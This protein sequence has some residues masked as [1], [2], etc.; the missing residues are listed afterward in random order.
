MKI[1]MVSLFHR[2]TINNNSNNNNPT[3]RAPECQKTS[4]ALNQPDYLV[5][6]K[7]FVPRSQLLICPFVLAMFQR[8]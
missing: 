7:L 4:V 3:C 8:H 6:A 5:I 1:Y 2:A